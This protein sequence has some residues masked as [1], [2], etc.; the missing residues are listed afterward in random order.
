MSYRPITDVWYCTRAPQSLDGTTYYGMYPGG[1]LERARVLLCANLDDPVLHVCGGF[2]HLYPYFGGYGTNDARLDM[3]RLTKPEYY[4]D[5]RRIEDY[6]RSRVCG[7]LPL[8]WRAMIA[9]SPYSEED[10]THYLPGSES[11]PKPRIL[12][13]NMLRSVQPG[14]KVGVLHYVSP[15]PPNDIAVR[16]VAKI[17]VAMPYDNR[18]RTFSVYEKLDAERLKRLPQKLL[19]PSLFTDLGDDD[20]QA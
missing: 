3:S 1:F 10:A 15:R 19:R 16:F 5:A 11:Y 20:E 2:S 17:T 8:P 14:C 6:P 4:G 12:L 18:D 9:D 7:G 13:S